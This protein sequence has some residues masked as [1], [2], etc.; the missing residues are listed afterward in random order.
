MFKNSAC[1]RRMSGCDL[2]VAHKHWTICAGSRA[3]NRRKIFGDSKSNY[4]S[5]HPMSELDSLNYFLLYPM[6][7]SMRYSG[8]TYCIC[9]YNRY[10]CR[11]TGSIIIPQLMKAYKTKYGFI[12]SDPV[13]IGTNATGFVLNIALLI[14]KLRYDKMQQSS[15]VKVWLPDI[16]VS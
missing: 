3:W 10:S 1:M 13:I 9:W 15:T 7:Y 14:M 4:G 2:L 5:K 11:H 16:F 6:L 12:R 8:R